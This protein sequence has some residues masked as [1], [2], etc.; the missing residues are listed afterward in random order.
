M[1][2]G[3]LITAVGFLPIATARSSTGEYTFA[4][5]AVVT[6]ALLISWVMAVGAV[7]FI[8][9]YLLRGR[10]TP[11][12]PANPDAHAK[13]ALAASP[14]PGAVSTAHGA[15]HALF[16]TPFYRRLR[17]TIEGAMRHRWITLG[18]TVLLLAAGVAGMQL[19][20]KQFFP[21]SD[22]A[23]ILVDLWLPEGA[24]LAA[25]RA[26]SE[27]LETWL[28]RDGDVQS[29]VAYVG[30][31][32][33]RYFLSL[34]QQLYRT[35]YAQFVVLT[36][37]VEARNR[38][39]P[40]LQTELASN[41]PG[42]RARAYLTPLGPPVAFPVQFRIGGPDVGTIKRIANQ[43][44][45]VVRANPYT[46]EPHLNWGER[47]PSI[48]V[49]VDQDRARAVGLS[50][51]QISRALGGVI[52]GATIGTLHE[53]DQLLP[54]IMRAPRNERNDLSALGSLPITTALGSTVPLSQ[55]ATLRQVMEEPILWRRSRIP[56]LTVNADVV[57]GVQGPDVMHQIQRQ[58]KTIRAGLMV[59]LILTLLMLQ[60][61]RFSLVLMVMLTAPLG[62]VGVVAALLVSGRPFGFVAMLGTIALAG[63]I[64][65]N[66]VILVDQ[67][68]QDIDEGHTPWEAVREATVRRFRPITLTA[69]AA[70][71][72]MIPLSR[73]VL[74]GPMAVSIMGG[75]VVATVLT[76][77]MVPALY[78][79]WYRIRPPQHTAA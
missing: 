49:D 58:L 77:L 7:P 1:L 65:R 72:A 67:I 64:M 29:F 73:D 30:N 12:A 35:N 2:T 9:T 37:D 40:R 38:L 53:G 66:T 54:V 46:V 63:I 17:A 23:E 45:E 74:W 61:R 42:V 18:I 50:S 21:P 14:E 6:L 5:F 22:R 34:D 59:G 79:A 20:T 68:R 31:G 33:P 55:V 70:I 78:V 75:L 71:L 10:D 69:A 41:F 52:D 13:Q 32:S 26:Q 28:A 76:L 16:H 3:T 48:Q 60:L 8:G 24:S 15:E 57:D 11:V 51:G 4:I 43:V 56:T 47:S 39:M 36:P 27:Q 44:L 25:T 19:T 62:I